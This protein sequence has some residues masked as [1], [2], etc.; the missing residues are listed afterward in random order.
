MPGHVF[1]VSVGFGR[2]LQLSPLWHLETGYGLGYYS[3]FDQGRSEA[4]RPIGQ[5]IAYRNLST[6]GSWRWEPLTWDVT[7]IPCCRSP[8]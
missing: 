3:D 2:V 7:T 8:G 4:L 6:T 1:D 5:L